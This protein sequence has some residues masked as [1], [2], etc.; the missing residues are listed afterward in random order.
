MTKILNSFKGLKRL[1]FS[2]MNL[3]DSQGY[4]LNS[5]PNLTELNLICVDKPMLEKILPK[6]P[7]LQKLYVSDP[8]LQMMK[9]IFTIP[10]KL[11]EFRYAFID[12]ETMTNKIITIEEV[13]ELYEA[14]KKS[15]DNVN[16]NIDI[17]QI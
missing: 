14:F 11:V 12:I 2:P 16:H 8:S 9:A 1:T 13:R 6:L 4:S 3:H 7:K 15:C 5:H 10:Q 17:S